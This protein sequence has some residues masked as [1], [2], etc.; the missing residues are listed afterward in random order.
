MKTRRRRLEWDC[1][2][3]R[4]L[5]SRAPG[6]MGPHH[7]GMPGD[8]QGTPG[9]AEVQGASPV[10]G[11][12]LAS[13]STGLGT[14]DVVSLQ[15]AASGNNLVLFLTQFEALSGTDATTRQLAASIMNDARNVELAL[16]AFAGG[17]GIGVGLPGNATGND[18]VLAQQMIAGVKAGNVDSTFSTL[19]VQ[20]EQS[21]V[22]Q[23]QAMA[24]GAQDPALRVF[25]AGVL[26]TEQADLA[27]AQGTGTLAPVSGTPS[28]T[29]LD[30][31]DLSTLSTFY[32]INVMERFLGQMTVLVTAKQPVSLYAAKLIGDHGQG[33]VG[34]GAYAATTGTY[35][36][37]TIPASDSAM[38][39]TVVA[40]LG[41]TR[42]GRSNRYDAVYLKQMIMGHSAALQYTKTVIATAQNP[43]LKQFAVNVA[44]TIYMHLLTARMLY[45]HPNGR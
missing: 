40:A 5:L 33:V 38:A 15:S 23:F 43:V 14:A 7:A 28:S 26:P 11:G 29:T 18:Q 9:M 8:G 21:M 17:T 16:N 19:I 1:L 27:A 30:A 32:A 12:G 31:S 35:L 25:A 3:T 10:T 13:V 22:A 41:S 6:A 44:P 2:E 36:P 20:A 39:S 4:A 45:R 34:L 24:T 42:P 37:P